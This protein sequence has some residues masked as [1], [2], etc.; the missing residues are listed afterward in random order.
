MTICTPTTIEFPSVK[1]RRVQAAFDGGPITSDGGVVLLGQVDRQL[2]LTRAIVNGGR[3]VYRVAR[4]TKRHLSGPNPLGAFPPVIL[5]LG[6]PNP[7]DPAGVRSH[8]N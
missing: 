5:S 4:E 7:I 2:G 8:R 3:K 6:S 1:R